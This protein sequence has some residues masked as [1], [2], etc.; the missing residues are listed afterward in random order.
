MEQLSIFDSLE[1]IPEEEMVRQIGEA[2]GIKFTYREDW[3]EWQYK[4]KKVTLSVHYGRYMCHDLYGERF[5]G[6]STSHSLG[7]SSGP[8]DSIEEAVNFARAGMKN[9]GIEL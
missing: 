6:V 9:L 5:I 2:L 3:K 8:M 4:I 1:M 7:G